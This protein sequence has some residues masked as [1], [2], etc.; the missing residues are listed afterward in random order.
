MNLYIRAFEDK[1]YSRWPSIYIEDEEKI[2]GKLIMV[3]GRPGA[4]LIPCHWKYQIVLSET[5][6]IF[7]NSAKKRRTWRVGIVTNSRNVLS[8]R[9][10]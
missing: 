1:N 10:G 3:S 2:N 4:E 8:K 6:H 5:P 7:R 9:N